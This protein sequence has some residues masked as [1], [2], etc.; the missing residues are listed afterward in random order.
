M[1]VYCKNRIKSSDSRLGK[2]K[3]MKGREGKAKWKGGVGGERF[4]LLWGV[5][6]YTH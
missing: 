2:G 4:C 3:E 1:H 5:C 6:I